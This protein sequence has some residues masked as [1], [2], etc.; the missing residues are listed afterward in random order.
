MLSILAMVLDTSAKMPR[1]NGLWLGPTFHGVLHRISC[2]IE[3]PRGPR[4]FDPPEHSRDPLAQPSPSQEHSHA[5]L[6]F[7]WVPAVGHW[8]A[9][10]LSHQGIWSQVHGPG[11]W[12]YRPP[13]PHP[14]HHLPPGPRSFRT[15]LTGE[16]VM[17]RSPAGKMPLEQ[18][19]EVS[20]S[21][22]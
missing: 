5:A 1:T 2:P 10:P 16:I 13:F 12:G 18:G 20:V 17:A 4:G 9:S 8:R 14:M 21:L 19:A 7:P 22:E 15:S 6:L 3:T 11:H